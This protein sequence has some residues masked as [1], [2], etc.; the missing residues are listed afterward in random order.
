MKLTFTTTQ[1]CQFVMCMLYDHLLNPDDIVPIIIDKDYN[2]LMTIMKH[3]SIKSILLQ[4][5]MQLDPQMRVKYRMIKNVFRDNMSTGS[6]Y[7]EIKKE[8]I[9]E[10][11]KIGFFRKTGKFLLKITSLGLLGGK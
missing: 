6:I 2:D 11:E 1:Y 9:P 3:R 5:Y 4:Y 7:I 10:E 8:H